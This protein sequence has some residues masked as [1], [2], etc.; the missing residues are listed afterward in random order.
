[1]STHRARSL[2]WAQDHTHNLRREPFGFGMQLRHSLLF[3]LLDGGTRR[4]DLLLRSRSGLRRSF[5]A[6]PH[7]PLTPCFQIFENLQ[8]R[9]AQALFISTFRS[10]AEEAI[11]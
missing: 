6:R 2:Y 3:V 4:F 10:A 5:G 7:R 9:F 1:M 11:A 8:A